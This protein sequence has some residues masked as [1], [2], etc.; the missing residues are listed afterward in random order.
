MLYALLLLIAIALVTYFGG[1]WLL[2]ELREASG[3]VG[4]RLKILTGGLTSDH[5]LARTRE[6]LAARGLSADCIVLPSRVTRVYD[7]LRREV[8]GRARAPA[9]PA[10]LVLALAVD[11]DRRTLYLR[12]VETPAGGAG[13][14]RE[15]VHGFDE[16]AALRR[17]ANAFPAALAPPGAEALELE[18]GDAQAPRYHLVLEP[19]WG[20]APADLVARV[21][22]MIEAGERPAG[23]PVVVR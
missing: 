1:R 11:V 20:V 18:L 21:R 4:T 6:S 7:A 3:A 8:I 17:V 9:L 5:L 12:A 22:A 23:A 14:E 16:I 19:D 2:A 15:A 13:R 10:A